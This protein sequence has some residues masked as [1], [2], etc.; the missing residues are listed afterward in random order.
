MRLAVIGGTGVAG[1]C[2]VESLRRAGHDT[3]VIAR[4]RGVDVSTGRGLDDALIGVE[5][6]IDVTNTQGPDAE[7]TRNLFGTAIRCLSSRW[8]LKP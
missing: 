1:R 3:V 8:G 6:V 2:I 4:S 5:T 7:A